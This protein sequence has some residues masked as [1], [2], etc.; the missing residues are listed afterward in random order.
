M[1]LDLLKRHAKKTRLDDTLTDRK[2]IDNAGLTRNSLKVYR[3]CASIKPIDLFIPSYTVR[4]L[5]VLSNIYQ[6][7]LPIIFISC[8]R[9][10]GSLTL[11]SGTVFLNEVECDLNNG[12]F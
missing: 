5:Y 12:E 4:P 9:I 3:I 11:D 7:L 1:R 6:R 8:S 10:H 2:T